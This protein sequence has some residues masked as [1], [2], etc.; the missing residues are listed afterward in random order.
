MKS[1]LRSLSFACMDAAE[2]YILVKY[3]NPNLIQLL[4]RRSDR[5]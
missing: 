2:M 1:K 4:R 5:R 3:V